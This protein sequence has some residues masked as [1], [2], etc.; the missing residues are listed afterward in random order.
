MIFKTKL[1]PRS[2]QKIVFFHIVKTGGSTFQ[3]IL[4][5]IYG[6]AFRICNDA[7][8]DSIKATLARSQCLEFHIQPGD[9][10]WICLHGE[11]VRQQRWDLIKGCH[12][13]T[14]LREPID[15][16]LSQYFYLQTIRAQVEPILHASGL[17]FPDSL[18]EFLRSPTGYNGQLS[19]LMG[20]TQR[21]G[22]LM[23]P[24]DLAD[25]KEMLLRLGMHVGLT[26]RFAD[27]M[28][29]FESVTGLRIPDAGIKN[30]NRNASR[31]KLADVPRRIRDQIQENSALDIELY[32][33]GRELFLED[34]SRC[35]KT[36][37]YG[38]LTAEDAG[39]GPPQKRKALTSATDAVPL[40]PM[41]R[42]VFVHVMRTGGRSFRSFLASLYGK[43]YHVCDDGSLHSVQADLIRFECNVFHTQ[44]DRGGYSHT[45]SQ[46]VGM[47]RW[48]LL[49]GTQVFTLLRD[50]LDHVISQYYRLLR[51]RADVEA[52]FKTEGTPFPESLE[53]Y[54]DS[55]RHC[56]RQLALLLGK[57]PV[58]SGDIVT[59]ECLADAQNMLKLPSFHVGL[60]ERFNDSLNLFETVI[61]R[62]SSR[63][64]LLKIRENP[65]RPSVESIPAALR[66]RI[67]EQNVLDVELHEFAKGLFE[68]DFKQCGP[69]RNYQFLSPGTPADKTV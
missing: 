31:P 49:E 47:R 18:T 53:D 10:G 12:A 43:S 69:T 37:K 28:N 39:A 30:Q 48:D 50:P 1:F 20:Q 27:S 54:V 2:S 55:P 19:F 59:R 62:R 45:H 34:L 57:R 6:D 29:V 68:R 60:T 26:E 36:R 21:D 23:T 63:P 5:A 7:S 9:N 46:L 22:A 14:M 15:Q 41:K 38:F 25:A 32:R 13:F 42:A 8:L 51:S 58:K 66:D 65:N 33:F 61:G 56:N 24:K 16:V 17:E 52:I 11:L 3:A 4:S 44:G 67:L 40:Q 35:A 64:H